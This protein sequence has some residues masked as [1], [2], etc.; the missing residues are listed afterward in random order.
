MNFVRF[1]KTPRITSPQNK[2][3]NS[4]A[5]S[6]ADAKKPSSQQLSL[7]VTITADFS[8]FAGSA[9]LLCQL[10]SSTGAALATQQ[11]QWA[12]YERE[13]KVN[14]PAPPS[15]S[16]HKVVVTPFDAS[17][18]T[19]FLAR[20]L[21]G[22][23]A[24]IVGVETEVFSNETCTHQDAVY[25]RFRSPTSLI[26]IAEQTGETIIRH[27]WDAGV[28]LSA[29][30]SYHQLSV[31][32]QALRTF[33]QPFADTTRPVRVLELGA[34]VGILGICIALAFPH[35]K[36]VITDLLDAQALVEENIRLNASQRP[37]LAQNASFRVLDWEKHPYPE[38]TRT[39]TFDLI[40]MADVTYNTATFEALANTLEHLL[41]TGS[42]AARVIC[43]GKRRHDEEEQFW[44]I[45]GKRGFVI[46][47]REIFSMDLEGAFAAFLDG[48]KGQGQH[49]VDFIGMRLGETP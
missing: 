44:N 28:I 4:K 49:I 1:V 35:A 8:P 14:F 2:R 16:R 5:N 38:W 29:A 18:S 20:F 36:V 27:V 19:N 37:D 13:V 41:T 10:V 17:P 34:G 47:Q 48:E 24:H 32:P 33:S 31:L 21:D 46:D 45:V 30:F 15:L 26:T 9:N 40:V 43:C 25:R 42:S 6:K 39:E 11:I 7:I 12:G 22:N 3:P 23:I